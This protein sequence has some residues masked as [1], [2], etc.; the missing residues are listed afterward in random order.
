MNAKERLRSIGRS[1]THQGPAEDT[2]LV[3][4]AS[5]F[6]PLPIEYMDFVAEFDGAEGWVGDEYVSLWAVADLWRFNH[7]LRLDLDA[8][9]LV[10]FGTN[11]GGEGFG[12]DT[13]GGGQ[14]VVMV[15]MIGMAW[16]LAI[17]QAEDFS[18][19]LLGAAGRGK[20]SPIA[21]Q[22]PNTHMNVY[23]IQP[24]IFGGSP[25]DQANKKLIKLED[26]IPVARW[27]NDRVRGR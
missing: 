27:W 26:F 12:F 22:P 3:K 23:E 7:G 8:P 16:D 18:Q 19:W 17:P 24:I 4:V 20:S 5:E 1:L 25:T 9:G 11:G 21:S 14:R 10:L 15:P 2:E 13:R 6:P